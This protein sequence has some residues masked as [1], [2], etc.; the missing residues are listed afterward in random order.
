L[1]LDFRNLKFA[2]RNKRAYQ[3]YE[4]SMILC[5]FT[6][7]IMLKMDKIVLYRFENSQVK[8]I[9]EAYFDGENLIIDGYDIGDF[10]EQ[11]WGDSDYEYSTTIFREEVLKLYPLF[12]VTEGDKE[13][14]LKAL[15]AGFHGNSCYSEFRN[16]MDINGIKYGSF[17]WM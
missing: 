7:E 13:G 2:R 6:G 15:E 11:Y 10:V 5:I 3:I 1:F 17:S 16:F 14:L 9:I 8:V 4:N 12:D